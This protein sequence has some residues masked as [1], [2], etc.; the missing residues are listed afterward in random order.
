MLEEDFYL[1]SQQLQLSVPLLRRI[2]RE[3]QE[4]ED[5]IRDAVST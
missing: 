1:A 3:Q 2:Q 5:A 4:L